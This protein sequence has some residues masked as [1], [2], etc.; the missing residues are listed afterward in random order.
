MLQ[1]YAT[2]NKNWAL[3]PGCLRDFLPKC[4]L[5]Q[6]LVPCFLQDI[7]PKCITNN[8]N[9]ALVPGCLRDFRPKCHLNQNHLAVPQWMAPGCLQGI[10][11]GWVPNKMVPGSLRKYQRNWLRS[12]LDQNMPLAAVTLQV[13]HS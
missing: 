9:W 11:P 3:V 10:L 8:Q 2:N 6:N 7:F 5:I 4:H 1:N 13:C 12:G